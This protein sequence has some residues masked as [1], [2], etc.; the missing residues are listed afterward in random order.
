MPSLLQGEPL[1]AR[2][3]RLEADHEARVRVFPPRLLELFF[4]PAPVL[5]PALHSTPAFLS[6]TPRTSPCSLSAHPMQGPGRQSLGPLRVVQAQGGPRGRGVPVHRGALQP[7]EGSLP[8]HSFKRACA[9]VV[10][11]HRG[12]AR[13]QARAGSCARQGALRHA[14][15]RGQRHAAG[16]LRQ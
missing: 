4:A 9:A 15:L 6:D 11:H 2:N 5:A 3:R 8:R 7:L 14:R 16:R 1:A 13:G 10:N 12:V